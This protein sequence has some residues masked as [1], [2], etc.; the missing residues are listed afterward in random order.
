MCGG[1]LMHVCAADGIRSRPLKRLLITGLMGGAVAI[2]LPGPASAATTDGPDFEMPFPCRDTWT[3]TSRYNHSPS[4]LSVDFNKTNDFGAPMVAAA[5]G[6]IPGGGNLC[7]PR[8]RP[9]NHR[10]H[11]RRWNSPLPALRALW[12]APG[13]AVRQSPLPGLVGSSGGSTGPHLHF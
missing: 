10:R 7:H 11:R 6:G 5:P 8:L 12:S 2:A 13:Q 1:E 4:A 3:G 9:F